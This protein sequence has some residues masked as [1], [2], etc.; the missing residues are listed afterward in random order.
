MTI[1]KVTG[2]L[3]AP[4]YKLTK[5]EIRKERQR[6]PCTDWLSQLILHFSRRLRSGHDRRVD[7]LLSIANQSVAQST[8]ERPEPGF[9]VLPLEESCSENRLADLF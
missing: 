2:A 4:R 7:P 1:P 3:A 5:I 6:K 8:F 9:V